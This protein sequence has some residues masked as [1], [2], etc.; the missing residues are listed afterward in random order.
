MKK[1]NFV[2]L[3]FLFATCTTHAQTVPNIHE[4]YNEKAMPPTPRAVR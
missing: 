3:G 2:A 1:A 4:A